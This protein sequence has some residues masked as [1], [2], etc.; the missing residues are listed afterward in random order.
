M[1]HGLPCYLHYLP[2]IFCAMFWVQAADKATAEVLLSIC[3]FPRSETG[4]PTRW[5][6][7]DWCSVSTF[8][9]RIH[10]PSQLGSHC[11]SNFFIKFLGT[12]DAAEPQLSG[13]F[14]HFSTKTGILQVIQLGTR[15]YKNRCFTKCNMMDNCWPKK[16]PFHFP[17][18]DV[19]FP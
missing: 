10:K 11:N 14:W 19:I 15:T 18:T 3:F 16:K 9:P 12:P 8:T 1:I 2:L 17:C 13:T 5:H 7:T 4:K 6:S